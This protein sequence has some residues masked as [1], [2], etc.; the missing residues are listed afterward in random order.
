MD[1][2]LKIHQSKIN[3]FVFRELG[4]RIWIL[5]IPFLI[6]LIACAKLQKYVELINTLAVFMFITGIMFLFKREYSKTFY[7]QLKENSIEFNFDLKKVNLVMEFIISFMLARNKLRHGSIEGALINFDE[8]ESVNIK[9]KE[10]VII[11]K[12]NNI[13]T[14]NSKIRVPKEIEDYIEIKLIFEELKNKL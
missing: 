12:H 14:N 2:K 6:I 3:Q 5:I 8:I 7:Y 1:K 13:L 11:S 9:S 10:I 4:A